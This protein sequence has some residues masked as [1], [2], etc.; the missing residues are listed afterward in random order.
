VL[1]TNVL[2]THLS[3]IEAGYYSEFCGKLYIYI[4]MYYTRWFLLY[5]FL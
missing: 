4:Y 5:A 3:W 2:N 1:S